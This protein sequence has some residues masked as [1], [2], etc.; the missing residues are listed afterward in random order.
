MLKDLLA[1]PALGPLLRAVWVWR[2]LRFG[3][4][5]LLLA[6][7]A[8]GWHQHAI[9]GVAVKDP[10]M[11]TNLTSH[12][13]WVWWIMGVVFLAFFFG[14][15]WCA[16]CPVGWLNA[17]VAEHGL[18]RELP[19]W[20]R[21]FLPVTVTLL[22]L[23]L[24]VYFLTIHR[25]PDYTA[26]LLALML[27]LAVAVGLLFRKRAFCSIFCPAG[28][29]FGLY[30]RVAPLQLRVKDAAVCTA[31]TG[32][33]CVAGDRI[34]QRF[35]MGRAIL[36]WHGRRGDCPV[37]L[38]PAEMRDSADCHLCL[39]CARNCGSDNILLGCRPWLADLGRGILSPSETVFFLV[40][41]G[42]LTANFSKVYVDLREAIFFLPEQAALLLGWQA[43][44]YYLLAVLWVALL[45][46]FLLLLPGY[47]ILRAGELQTGRV[48]AAP[49]ETG[50]MPAP[51]P[52]PGFWEA[53]GALALPYIPL[54]LSAH[55][56]LAVVKINAKAG[57][58]PFALRDASGVQSYLAMNVMKT[59]AAPG[60]LIPLDLL[61][62]LVVLLLAGGYLLSLAGAGRVARSLQGRF[63]PK[64][65][66]AAAVVGLTLA[67]TLYLATVI[68]WLFI[69]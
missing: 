3:F 59:A 57:Y 68:R 37:D 49:A 33:E 24:A 22:A 4:L 53:F 65:Y 10:L 60:V 58:L 21:N 18:R 64:S 56:V 12:L 51:P 38:L 48:A 17:L 7:I 26:V 35:A 43:G 40:L 45:F 50:T 47:L 5:A 52:R 1:I 2:L 66:I 31:C 44:G 67:G 20:L 39:N 54:I 29:V 13:F 63:A 27:L 61:K 8:F 69:R 16:V 30:A 55:M 28:A 14:R 32:K 6:M 46:P 25:Y 23:Q 36:F 19:L 42:M 15:A 34:W 41:L 9:P 11:Y 62:W